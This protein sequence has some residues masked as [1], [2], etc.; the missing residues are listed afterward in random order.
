MAKKTLEKGVRY[1]DPLNKS[2]VYVLRNGMASGDH[3]ML[4]VEPSSG[5][6]KTIFIK[7]MS[8]SLPKRLVPIK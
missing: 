6:L 3:L 4:A 5:L 8:K 7:P 1:Y 2:M